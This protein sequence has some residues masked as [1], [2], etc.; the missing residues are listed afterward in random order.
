MTHT[1]PTKHAIVNASRDNA[2]TPV[3]NRRELRVIGMSRSGN[4]AIIN[5]IR[6]Q[7]WGRV[8]FLNCAEPKTNPFESARPLE[9]GSG[10]EANF[11][12][13]DLENE[14]RGLFA[15]KDS[16]IFSHE[17]CFLGMVTR[18]A[19]EEQHDDFVGPS[20]RRIDILVLRDPFN[21]FASRL[22]AGYSG[23]TRKTAIRIWKQ[24]AREFL[25]RGAYLKG[26]HVFISY[27][28]WVT[29]R[30]Y[31]RRLA[32]QLNLPFT[33]AGFEEVAH[34]GR[35]SSFDGLRYDGRASRMK[36][37]ERWKTF[38]DDPEYRHL[39]DDEMIR[40]SE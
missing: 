15:E 31:R 24:H 20:D 30:D 36:V 38:A 1:D 7:S 10:I 18:G 34:T 23:V 14:R 35:G 16:L 33:D 3:V 25:G 12:E 9:H 39:F 37:L 27:N 40:L 6:N 26:E 4:H 21:L 13:F 19:F 5:W 11:P 22:K 28:R 29:D 8:C 17:D 32:E 2:K